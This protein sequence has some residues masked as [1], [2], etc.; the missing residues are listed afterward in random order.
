MSIPTHALVILFVSVIQRSKFLSL[1]LSFWQWSCKCIVC[2]GRTL[3][4]TLHLWEKSD[5]SL[6]AISLVSYHCSPYPMYTCH[7]RDQPSCNFFLCT[8]CMYKW[9]LLIRTQR[10]GDA[11]PGSCRIREIPLTK[12]I[13]HFVHHGSLLGLPGL[14]PQVPMKQCTA[15]KLTLAMVCP[16]TV[17]SLLISLYRKMRH[18]GWR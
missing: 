8:A 9:C 14:F 4:M 10:V 18:I 11:I 13:P 3:I 15:L 12:W 16:P 7:N 2:E 6:M 17:L 1:S 5:I